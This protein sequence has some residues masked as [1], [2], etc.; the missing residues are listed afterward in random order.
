VNSVLDVLIAGGTVVD[1]TGLCARPAD[2][3]LRDGRI[4]AVGEVEEASRRTVDA[5]GLIVAPGFIDLHTHYDAQLFWDPTASPSTLHGVTTVLGGNCGFTLAP[6]ASADIDYLM[7]LMSRVEGLPLAALEAGLDWK[8]QSFGDWLN[9]LEGRLGVNAGFL[10][11][12][13]ALRRA[14][15]GDQF[16]EEAT[17]TQIDMMVRLLHE[18]LSE[19][20]LG[21][22]T[23]TSTSHNHADGTPIPTRYASN[24]ELVS[25]A[26][27]LRS[28]PGTTL[29]IIVPGCLNKFTEDET[30]LLIDMSIASNRPINWN[31]LN[32]DPADPARYQHQLRVSDQAAER[33]ARVIA[34]AMPFSSGTRVNFYSGVVLDGLPQWSEILGLPI[35]ER[36]TALLNPAVRKRLADGARSEKGTVARYA[37]WDKMTIV[38]TFSEANVGLT[39]RK[40]GEIA[41]ERS[42]DPFDTLLD[43]VIA[44]GLRTGLAPE[45][46][47]GVA[48][49]AMSVEDVRTRAEVWKDPRIVLGGSDAGAHLD[50]MC[51]AMYTTSMIALAVRQHQ[52][53]TIEAAVRLLTDVPAR[54]YGLRGRGRISEGWAADMVLFDLDRIASGPLHTRDD[55]P[56]G[57]SRLFAESIGI[58]SVFVN[59]VRVVDGGRVTG[60]ESGKLLRS[61]TDIETVYP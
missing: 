2:V 10:V 9:R 40:I 12:H 38:E 20:G 32:I 6:V 15:M 21:F 56:G 28:H 11:G 54:L 34:L 57:A 27:A 31:V 5:T 8:W 17:S 16:A 30:A 35:T 24:G 45:L 29:E 7:R 41:S 44:D 55:L 39:G 33:G 19:G 43:I 47:P 37:R 51:G 49:E 23:S 18:S 60:A 3:G 52:V 59:G 42:A 22:S 46:P 4:V 25:L 50:M 53:L 61:I 48:T 26:R 36:I 14:V 13:S 58:E 1:G